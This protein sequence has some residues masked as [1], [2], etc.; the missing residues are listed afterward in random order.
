MSNEVAVTENTQSTDT[1]QPDP[2]AKNV[3]MYNPVFPVMTAS[4]N[5]E[6]PVEDMA[7]DLL[8]LASDTVNYD[9]GFTTFFDRQRIDYIRGFKQL[10]EAIYGVT[11]SFLRELK[12]E[13]NPQKCSIHT[14]A[15]VMRHGGSHGIHNHPRSVVSGT[16]YIQC[17]KES[18]PLVIENP[19]N[20]FRMHEPAVSRVED[21]TPFTSPSMVIEP[22]PNMMVIW[23]SWLYHYVPKVTKDNSVPR[24]AISFNVDF[25]PPGA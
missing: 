8:K 3:I 15:S 4:V 12:Y 24:I 2:N 18:V 1:E 5:L 13:V 16:F 17:D 7:E 20:A 14:W 25:L 23:P 11:N 6:M 19:T 21:F 9:G 10:E 22:K